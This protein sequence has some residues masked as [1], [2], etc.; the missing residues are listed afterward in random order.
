MIHAMVQ[1]AT[2]QQEEGI[3]AFAWMA[4]GVWAV[5]IQQQNGSILA[6]IQMPAMDVASV[7]GMK[8]LSHFIR[9]AVSVIRAGMRCLTAEFP[10][11]HNSAV[12]LLATV[13]I[14]EL[15]VM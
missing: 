7:S 9:L 15:V 12:Y 4:G 13:V 8:Q 2:T 3:S 11:I 14:L 1:R 6:F 5:T 10:S